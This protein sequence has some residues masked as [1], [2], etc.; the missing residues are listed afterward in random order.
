[1]RDMRMRGSDYLAITELP[2]SL[3]TNEQFSRFAHRYAVAAGLVSGARVLEVAC[4]AG[5]GLGYLA[6]RM[7]ET[8]PA[9]VV[10]MDLTVG[11]LQEARARLPAAVALAG[12]D[13]HHLPFAPNSF[14]LALCFEAIYYLADA[15]AFLAEGRRVLA[16]GGTLVLCLTNPDWPD[17]VP[18]LLTTRYPSVPELACSLEHAGFRHVRLYGALPVTAASRLQRMRHRLRRIVLKSR[19]A[20]RLASRLGPWLRPWAAR[21]MGLGDGVARPLPPALD[22]ITV[23]QAI[24]GEGMTPL[25]LDRPDRAH[26][27]LYALATR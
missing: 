23:A 7:A 12:G 3:L 5:V 22:A 11:L 15:G 16:P 27:V 8:A 4:G 9:Q 19:P 21:L 14:D 26:R 20:L 24:I 18:G 6:G 2:G 13:A 25:A 17:F 1:M 10:G